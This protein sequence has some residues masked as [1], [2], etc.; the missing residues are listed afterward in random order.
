MLECYRVCSNDDPGLTKTYFT[1]RS[2]LGPLC[3]CMG[4]GKTMDISETTVVYDVKIGRCS[5]LNEYM[6]LMSTNGQGHS[7]TSQIQYFFQKL[8]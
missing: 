4:K 1:A 7:L 2:N 5:Q 6:K 3:F 8:L